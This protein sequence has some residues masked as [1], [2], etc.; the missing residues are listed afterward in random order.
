MYIDT[1]AHLTSSMVLPDLMGVLERAKRAGVAKIVNICTDIPSLEEGLALSLPWIHHTAATTPHDVAQEGEEFFPVVEAA[2]KAGKLCAIGET[3]LDYFYVHSPRAIQQEFLVRY[4]QLAKAYAL[5]LV[6]HC[7]DAFEDL[8]AIADREYPGCKAVLHCFTGTWEEAQL[9]LARGW[10]LSFS[11]IVTFKKSESLRLVAAKAPLDRILVET[12][13]PYLAPQSKRG[14][15]NE[16]AFITETFALI[17]SLKQLDGELF[18][19]HVAS[20]AAQLFSF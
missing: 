7:R 11:G 20:N 13:T 10:Y 1:H 2:A 4:L 17:A 8:F 14:K 19:Q 18:A 3:G 16:P 5:P 9:V 12:D 6:F 15:T